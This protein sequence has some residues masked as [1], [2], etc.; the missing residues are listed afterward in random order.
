MVKIKLIIPSLAMQLN[1]PLNK[2]RFLKSR[3]IVN[4]ILVHFFAQQY[5]RY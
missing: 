3:E 4:R 5:D 1:V 2:D